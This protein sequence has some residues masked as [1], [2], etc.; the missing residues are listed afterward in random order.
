MTLFWYAAKE[1]IAKAEFISV[2]DLL[3]SQLTC[4][5]TDPTFEVDKSAIFFG[6]LITFIR[7]MRTK[8]LRMPYL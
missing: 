6:D 7:S 8:Q 1:V 4:F 5:R 3:G 2:E